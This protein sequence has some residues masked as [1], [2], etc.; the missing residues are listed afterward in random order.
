V[1]K[2]IEEV[3]GWTKAAVGF[4]KTHHRGL[5]RIGYVHIDSHGRQS[6][7]ADEAGAG[8]GVANAGICLWL[9]RK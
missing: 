1:R 8:G 9:V 3:F 7:P 5:A 6:G 4:R 2:R